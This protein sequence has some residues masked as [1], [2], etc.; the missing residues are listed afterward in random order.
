MVEQAPK[1]QWPEAWYMK[2][3]ECKDQKSPKRKEPNEPA[4]VKVLQPLGD[5]L[6]EV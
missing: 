6:L 2:K 4:S 1:D 3:G 5:L